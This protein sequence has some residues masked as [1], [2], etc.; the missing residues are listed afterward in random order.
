V[1]V[2]ARMTKAAESE[3]TAG[4]G[5]LEPTGPIERGDRRLHRKA[6]N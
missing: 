2:E 1:A 5:Y 3:K 4:A 6:S